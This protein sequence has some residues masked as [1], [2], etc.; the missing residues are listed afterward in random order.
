VGGDF[1]EQIV[2]KLGA[3][4]GFVGVSD[5]LARLSMETPTPN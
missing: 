4:A 2:I 5:V 1:V 3:A